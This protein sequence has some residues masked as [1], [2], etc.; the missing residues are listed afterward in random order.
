M[1]FRDYLATVFNA[2]SLVRGRDISSC[3]E[4]DCSFH[5]TSRVNEL[6][7]R[8]ECDGYKAGSYIADGDFYLKTLGTQ[9]VTQ[10]IGPF[11]RD[12]D[13]PFTY[14]QQSVSRF[15]SFDIS[16]GDPFEI[17]SLSVGVHFEDSET[18]NV[19]ATTVVPAGQEGAVGFT[20]YY[21]CSTGTLESCQG[22]RTNLSESC[23]PFLSPSGVMQGEY[24]LIQF[25]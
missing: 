7:K 24:G 10:T 23:R 18:K 16:L 22:V 5:P 2:V 12:R 15:T 8:Q 6:D 13:Y 3:V 4:G 25:G 17:I 21:Q 19:T 14:D 9:V 1:R 11:T 20:P